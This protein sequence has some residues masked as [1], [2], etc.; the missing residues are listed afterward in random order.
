MMALAPPQSSL[1]SPLGGR[2]FSEA[3]VGELPLGDLQGAEHAA[4]MRLQIKLTGDTH[5]LL[6]GLLEAI[7]GVLG[8]NADGEG[9]LNA[10]AAANVNRRIAELWGETYG[11]WVALFEAARLQAVRLPLGA[12]AV[13]HQSKLASL[14][15]ASEQVSKW[16]V[17]KFA[18]LQEA[19]PVNIGVAAANFFEAQLQEVLDATAN[20]LYS[21]GFKLSSRIWNL[22]QTGLAAIQRIITETVANGDS[23]WNAAQRLEAV[24]GAGQDCPRWTS[25]RLRLTKSE[26][27]AGDT[28]GL[29]SGGECSSQ[30]VAYKALRLARNEIQIAHAAAT[31]A[32]FARQPWIEAERINLSPSHPPIGCACEDIVRGGDN[33]DGVYPLGSIALPV[34]VQCLCFK[35]AE[36]MPDADFAKRMRG[37]VRGEESW[38]AMDS[39]AGWLG[40]ARSAVTTAITA[41]VYRQLTLAMETWLNGDEGDMDAALE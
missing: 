7:R 39:Y 15:V 10:L 16:Q 14:Q 5:G 26:I 32:I 37:W 9:R 8:S 35:T 31:D 19:D 27:A 25:T 17:G 22:D 24:L 28:R 1:R 38:P 18:S 12:L 23:A 3:A 41:E 11:A 21:D 2:F 33:G 29:I 13:G 30:G 34:H 6:T 4:L 40:V 36:L 20:R